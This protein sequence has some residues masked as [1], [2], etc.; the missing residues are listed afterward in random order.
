MASREEGTGSRC[1]LA[2]QD[3][4]ATVQ[5]HPRKGH[6]RSIMHTNI[7]ETLKIKQVYI[8]TCF[9]K[10]AR[11]SCVAGTYEGS[12]RAATV[13]NGRKT[14]VHYWFSGLANKLD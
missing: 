9:S 4:E 14:Q 5:R 1:S 3:S 7:A 8:C 11:F 2:G 13:A 12:P 10:L 6:R